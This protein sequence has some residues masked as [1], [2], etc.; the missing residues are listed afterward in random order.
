MGIRNISAAPSR[1][2]PE[3]SIRGGHGMFSYRNYSDGFGRGHP[4]PPTSQVAPPTPQR[5]PDIFAEAGR[6]ATEYLVAKGVLPQDV[7]TRKWQN[8][9]LK[10][11]MGNLRGCRQQ[12]G[13]IPPHHHSRNGSDGSKIHSRD[14]S[15]SKSNGSDSCREMG[16]SSSSSEKAKSS[17]NL[18]EKGTD[19]EAGN[20]RQPSSQS[21]DIKHVSDV[22]GDSQSVVDNFRDS[23]DVARDGKAVR[24]ET[25]VE[26]PKIVD[27]VKETADPQDSKSGQVEQ[28][29][30]DEDAPN[31]DC[32]AE[33]ETL[34]HRGNSLLSLSSFS[35]VPTKS[36][37]ARGSKNDLV[38]IAEVEKSVNTSQGNNCSDGPLPRPEIVF[39]DFTVDDSSVIEIPNQVLGSKHADPDN[40]KQTPEAGE[41]DQMDTEQGKFIRSHSLPLGS[42]MNEHKHNEGYLGIGRC[43]SMNIERGEKRA[44]EYIDDVAL[45]KKPR[46]WDPTKVTQMHEFSNLSHSTLM[47]DQ[48]GVGKV[49]LAT[50]SN[51]M[52]QKNGA[53]V[54][55]E[56]MQLFPGSFKIC[57]LNTVEASQRN[58]ISVPDPTLLLPSIT[59]SKNEVDVSTNNNRDLSATYN[60]CGADGK[61]IEV[62]DL[63]DDCLQVDSVFESAER[64]EGTVFMGSQSFPDHAQIVNDIS[65]VQDGYDLMMSDFL[66]NDIGGSGNVNSLPNDVPLDNREG[67]LGDDE[68]IYMSLGEIPISFLGAWGQSNQDYDNKPF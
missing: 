52:L 3:S 23:D 20:L 7:F 42:F 14:K 65:G 18:V 36:R 60:R 10:I 46:E 43:S 57:D 26:L 68:S 48:P 66:G 5:R 13:D 35:K 47:Q 27:D 58:E 32:A 44:A 63:D 11:F 17:L 1:I 39:K 12:E 45:V 15:R 8:G 53:E 21:R 56:E 64:K 33:D 2:A 31:H 50:G 54:Y 51:S 29:S 37:S 67:I 41:I 55:T 40:V 49:G 61:E 24:A 25:D 38:P 28:Q 22:K 19:S 30:G 4:R 6:L 16:R 34:N 59:E 9:S 62:I